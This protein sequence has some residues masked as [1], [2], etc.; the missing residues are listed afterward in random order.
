MKW[1]SKL[2]KNICLFCNKQKTRYKHMVYEDGYSGLAIADY[3]IKKCNEQ[4][5]PVTNMAIL[6]MIYFAHGFAYPLLGRKLIKDPFYAWEFGPVE[7]NTYKEFRKY[8]SNPIISI[9]NKTNNIIDDI[10]K[11]ET[12][13]KF[14][15][16][17]I[18][19]AQ[20]DPFELSKRSHEKGGPWDLTNNNDAISDK[21]IE[22]FF[23][24][25]CNG[26]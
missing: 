9:F 10:S 2:M 14:L 21:I 25:Q 23:Y 24:G 16:K 3:F 26:E 1:L 8:G 11:D 18:P 4:G 13:V 6:K 19:L 15:N 20:K 12:L 22:A 17:V 7:I 5:I